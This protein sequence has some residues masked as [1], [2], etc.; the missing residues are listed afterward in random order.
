[1]KQTLFLLAALMSMAAICMA[2]DIKEG[3]TTA[4]NGIENIKCNSNVTLHISK[5]SRATVRVVEKGRQH[6][7]VTFNG[8]KLNID[9]PSDGNGNYNIDENSI[10]TELFVTLPQMID[11][12]NSGILKLDAK[13]MT[14]S[15]DVEIS[16]NGHAVIDL[17]KFTSISGAFSFVNHGGAN[18][19]AELID[20]ANVNISNSGV[21]RM[22]NGVAIRAKNA[23][24][25]VPGVIN[26]TGMKISAEKCKLSCAGMVKGS[27][28]A[29]NSDETTMGVSGVYSA[30]TDVKGK[31][32]TMSVS[33]MTGGKMTFDGGDMNV[34][35]T[36]ECD[37]EIKVKCNN[38]SLSATGIIRSKVTG[39]AG[40]ARLSGNVGERC[41]KGLNAVNVVNRSNKDY[42][43]IM[44]SIDNNDNEKVW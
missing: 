34:S 29:I 43:L 10:M 30:D 6:S 25:S 9:A 44:R 11:V 40:T 26:V 4:I 12:S 37:S 22:E 32:L 28:F 21:A 3:V 33:G 20:A 36:G 1:M 13:D 23:R 14:A 2:T 24:I 7:E 8:K 35:C 18:F 16:N 39:T 27:A 15:A 17:G 41:I 19:S 42:E 5:G 38:V 31:S